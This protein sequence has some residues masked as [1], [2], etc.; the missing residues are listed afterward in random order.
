MTIHEGYGIEEESDEVKEMHR[1]RRM[2]MIFLD[3]VHVA[4]DAMR[5]SHA[6]WFK[7]KKW[8]VNML[9]RSSV[10]GYV[11]D[12]GVYFYRGWDFK[13]DNVGEHIALKH[14]TTLVEKLD[15]DVSLH[16]Y[17]GK[18]R[19]DEGEV[20]PNDRDLGP[21]EELLKKHL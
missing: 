9:M 8:D 5:C 12:D 6:D 14:L 17:G 21:I 7:R 10:R 1:K 13:Y 11:D 15:V 2:Y 16:L 20:W 19:T 18:I 4:P 3:A